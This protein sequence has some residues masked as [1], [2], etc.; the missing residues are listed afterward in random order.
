MTVYF[1]IAVPFLAVGAALIVTGG[2]RADLLEARDLPAGKYRTRWGIG[3][4]VATIACVLMTIGSLTSDIPGWMKVVSALVL[5][6][7]L[8][9]LLTVIRKKVVT[10][11][12]D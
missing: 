5:V 11:N 8:A 9:A 7:L 6:L 3:I 2:M 10:R 4:A 12:A 1:L